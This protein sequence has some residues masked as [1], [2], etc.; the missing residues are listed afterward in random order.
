[1]TH[2]GQ[3][4]V[5]AQAQPE[6]Q[7]EALAITAHSCAATDTEILTT[8]FVACY[9]TADMAW[10]YDS[11]HQEL[12]KAS[13]GTQRGWPR[14]GT[15]SCGRRKSEVTESEVTEENMLEFRSPMRGLPVSSTHTPSAI[16]YLL[17]LIQIRLVS[18]HGLNIRILT[19]YFT[20]EYYQSFKKADQPTASSFWV[21]IE[22][23]QL[24]DEYETKI[25]YVMEKLTIPSTWL[26]EQMKTSNE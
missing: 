14:L 9:L 21:S 3:A 1:M 12:K 20:E 7:P 10:H 13:E 19:T 11:D 16:S 25:D 8:E 22:S 2:A 6:A 15:W 18:I 5:Q 17:L 24:P 26:Q 4:E 23:F